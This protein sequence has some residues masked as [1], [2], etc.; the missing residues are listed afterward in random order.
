MLLL[1]IWVLYYILFFT[2][3]A[4]YT[5]TYRKIF[6]F[7]SNRCIFT[8]VTI[9]LSKQLFP[10]SRGQDDSCFS[11]NRASPRGNHSDS[12]FNLD[13]LCFNTTQASGIMQLPQTAD[14]FITTCFAGL[15]AEF[16][17]PQVGGL[18]HF[19]M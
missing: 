4:L 3:W 6:G 14:F 13:S 1:L 2:Y 11:K 15:D 7:H 5:S 16:T 12:H 19:Q 18:I 8:I 17:R 10:V 9:V